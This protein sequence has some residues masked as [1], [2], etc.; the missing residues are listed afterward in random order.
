MKD[1][2]KKK[3]L[4]LCTGSSCRSQM[5]EALIN[6]RLSDSWQTWSARTD[7]AGYVHLL[8]ITSLKEI[9][10]RHLGLSNSIAEMLQKDFDLVIT[11]YDDAAENCPAWL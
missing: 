1:Q 11:V 10:G 5:A 4:I 6:A 7:P 2:N 3:G 9:G 8:A